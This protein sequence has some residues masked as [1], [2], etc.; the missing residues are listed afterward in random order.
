VPKRR[1]T[2]CPVITK[3][4]T[5]HLGA[6]GHVRTRPAGKGLLPVHL[7]GGRRPTLQAHTLDRV[8]SKCGVDLIAQQDGGQV[9]DQDHRGQ[10]V[11]VGAAAHDP[12]LLPL[13]ERLTGGFE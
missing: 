5:A 12:H 1:E 6:S 10:H 2:R 11:V 3:V 8:E 13:P 4:L 9:V 7:Q